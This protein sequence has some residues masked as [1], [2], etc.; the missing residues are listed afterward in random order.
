MFEFHERTCLDLVVVTPEELGFE[1]MFE[2]CANYENICAKAHTLGLD[3][4][5]PEPGMLLA[6]PQE[7]FIAL[8]CRDI[9]T[10]YEEFNLI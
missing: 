2:S 6:L 8:G 4:C 5:P 1:P 3:N 9:I 10:I 7:E